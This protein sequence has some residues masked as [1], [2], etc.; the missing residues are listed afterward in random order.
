MI[1]GIKAAGVN[2]PTQKAFINNL[3][4]E[5]GYTASPTSN[6]DDGWFPPVDF[7]AV[8][9]QPFQCAYFVQL[10]NKQFVPQF[11]GAPVC[12]KQ[13]IHNG[14][15]VPVSAAAAGTATTTTTVAK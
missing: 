7:S 9:N 8:F 11:N 13:V 10:T 1:E 12:A 3:R 2:C 6:P 15:L 14:K 5:K 4:M